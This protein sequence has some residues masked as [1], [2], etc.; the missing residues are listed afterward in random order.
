MFNKL[1]ENIK[2]IAKVYTIVEI[3]CCGFLSIDLL[4]IDDDLIGWAFV[5][6]IIGSALSWITGCFMCAYGYFLEYSK[7]ISETSEQLSKS[8]QEIL[9]YLVPQ[10]VEEKLSS[11]N[12][13]QNAS[14]T[15]EYITS[16]PAQQIGQ[17]PNCKGNFFFPEHTDSFTCP[18]CNYLFNNK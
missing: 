8:T 15:E 3:I 2:V 13:P 17:C 5:V 7:K 11:P 12:D 18:H 4:T 10:K 9:N 6:F 1:D 16:S 14:H